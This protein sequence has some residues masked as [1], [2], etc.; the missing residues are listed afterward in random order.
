MKEIE[1]FF[2][3]EF[4]NRLDDVIVFRPLTRED[5]APHR[6]VTRSTRS[7]SV[8]SQQGYALELDQVAKDYLIDKGTTPS[9]A[10]RPLRRSIG[11]YVEDPLSEM[12]LS[13][14]FEGAV[15]IDAAPPQRVPTAS[16]RI[17]C[18]LDSVPQPKAE[19]DQKAQGDQ[20][21]AASSG[22]CGFC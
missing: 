3:P 19:P 7:G 16:R 18:S 22:T 4:I 11:Q 12:L 20:P 9:A 14:T 1:R 17:I 2:R 21:A 13:G 8:W 6:R 15:S 5:L 10:R